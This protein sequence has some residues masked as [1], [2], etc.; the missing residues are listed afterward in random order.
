MQSVVS[1]STASPLANTATGSFQF[2]STMTHTKAG[3]A[4]LTSVLVMLISI[5]VQPPFFVKRGTDPLRADEP[6]YWGMAVTSLLAGGLVLAFPVC[7][8]YLNR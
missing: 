2:L 6:C 8:Q 4:L 1:S 7:C 5:S 3:L